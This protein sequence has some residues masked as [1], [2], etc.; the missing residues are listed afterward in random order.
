MEE[1]QGGGMGE[2]EEYQIP[3]SPLTAES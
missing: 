2:R 3:P 1:Q